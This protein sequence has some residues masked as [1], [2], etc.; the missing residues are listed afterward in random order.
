MSFNRISLV[1]AL[2]IIKISLPLVRAAPESPSQRLSGS[3]ALLSRN[4][5]SAVS[6]GADRVTTAIG[7][8]ITEV[9][10][11]TGI[12]TSQDNS[13]VVVSGSPARSSNNRTPDVCSICQEE[14]NGESP[15]AVLHPCGHRYHAN[16]LDKWL[17]VDFGRNGNKTT[18]HECPLCR[19]DVLREADWSRLEDLTDQVLHSF[20]YCPH[21][22]ELLRQAHKKV[23]DRE[24]Q[25]AI[26]VC[27]KR[28]GEYIP[29]CLHERRE[30]ALRRFD[31]AGAACGACFSVHCL[32]QFARALQFVL[33]QLVVA[34]FHHD[35]RFRPGLDRVIF[36][37]STSRTSASRD[38]VARQLVESLSPIITFGA[39]VLITSITPG[40]L[41]VFPL[42]DYLSLSFDSASFRR[43][44]VDYA[45]RLSAVM[46]Y[47]AVVCMQKKRGPVRLL[48]SAGAQQLREVCS[49]V[50]KRH[51]QGLILQLILFR[52]ARKL[53]VASWR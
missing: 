30:A 53:Y 27:G 34:L 8:G 17:K 6:R 22:E 39:S 4:H 33:G 46:A 15:E 35:G 12:V 24:A 9:T 37:R 42:D 13:A 2:S 40:L 5:S 32:R 43:I 1:F 21:L 48:S 11:D 41:R 31:E 19:G 49:H 47:Y 45:I 28:M 52:L 38:G 36:R 29:L 51:C 10:G 50:L 14:F 25:H 3:R 16:C 18:K 23:T 20:A 44:H 26:Q 7:P